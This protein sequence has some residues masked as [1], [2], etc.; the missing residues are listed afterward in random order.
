MELNRTDINVSTDLDRVILA[1]GHLQ[2]QIPYA[3]TLTISRHLQAAAKHSMM[4]SGEPVYNW[5]SLS[6]IAIEVPQSLTVNETLRATIK[7]KFNWQ[8]D[9]N[10]ETVLLVIDNYTITLHFNAALQLATL[11]IAN[12]KVAR[13]WA[14]DHNK[15]MIVTGYLSNAEDNYKRIPQMI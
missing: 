4:I 2:I 3:A 9:V 6:E 12:A 7:R 1:I 14:G 10:S 11:L 5:Q 15:Q 8:I 13:A